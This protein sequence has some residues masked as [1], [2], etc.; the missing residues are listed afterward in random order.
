MAVLACSFAMAL[1]FVSRAATEQAGTDHV[2][3]EQS[4]TDGVAVTVGMDHG[5]EEA[6]TAVSL[7]LQVE[8]EKGTEEISFSFPSELEDAVTGYRYADGYLYLY[9]AS[10]EGIFD[11]DD[12]LYL[13]ELTADAKT[14]AGL[15]A[16]VSY[17]DGT[18]QTANA[19]YGGKNVRPASVSAPIQLSQSGAG[20]PDAP[21]T[22]DNSGSGGSGSGSGG[23]SGSGG[24][25]GSGGSGSGSGGSSGSGSGGSS[26]SGSGSGSGSGGGSG[27]RSGAGSGS[28]LPSYV[29]K[30][31]WRQDGDQWYFTDQSGKAYKNAW[32][33]VVNPYANT[34]AGQSVFDWFRFD[35]EGKMQTGWVTDTDGNTY[36]L[37]PVSDNT[38]GKMQTGWVWI[39]DANGVSRCYYFNPN[40]DGTRGRLMKNT[41][42]DGS[43][44]NADGAWVVNGV[45]QTRKA[46]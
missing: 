5:Y 17:V 35:E 36:Y 20:K 4:G 31:N 27:S 10:N 12:E 16:M 22:G 44:V 24:G 3:L 25:S 9:V 34:A 45:V 8:V 18:F 1:P 38:R 14:S 13:G 46:N 7:T 32:A 6:V 39:P 15:T 21:D 19:A 37:N 40:S 41:T 23:S 33:A 42:I 11:S 43:T 30:G 26:D 29:V 28:A 2:T